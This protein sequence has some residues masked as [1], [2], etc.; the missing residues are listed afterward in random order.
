MYLLVVEAVEL[1]RLMWNCELEGLQT[2]LNV[3]K[4]IA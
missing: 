2:I 1:D 3:S 4:Q